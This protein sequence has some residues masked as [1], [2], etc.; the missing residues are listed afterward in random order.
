M[1]K[2]I[3]STCPCCFSEMTAQR[4]N[5]AGYRMT[6]Y[7]CTNDDCKRACTEGYLS[8]FWSGWKQKER[9]VIQ[10]IKNISFPS[11]TN[12]VNHPSS[13]FTHEIR[14]GISKAINQLLEKI[15]TKGR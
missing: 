6:I 10:E 11:V 5:H 1:S 9:Q 13:S 14:F 4:N 8:G 2:F 3:D 12:N 15:T 7:T